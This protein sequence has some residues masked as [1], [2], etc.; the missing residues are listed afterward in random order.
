VLL[1]LLHAAEQPFA[2]G[3]WPEDW[4]KPPRMDALFG[5][6]FHPSSVRRANSALGDR[7]QITVGDLREVAIRGADVIVILDVLHYLE[8]A[9]QD[10]LLDRIRRALRPR[11]RLLAR[12]CDGTAGM[13]FALTCAADWLACAMR[14]QLYS[15]FHTRT[16]AAWIGA[17]G[18]HGFEVEHAPMSAGTPFANVLLQASVIPR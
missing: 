1:A 5:V 11:G 13:H 8:P 17:F 12:V 6:D 2:V 14:G 9:A 7:A 3:N 10:D 18:R 15:R 4:A 16:L